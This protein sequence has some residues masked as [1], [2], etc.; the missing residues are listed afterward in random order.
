MQG[1]TNAAPRYTELHG[2]TFMEIRML[3][4]CITFVNHDLFEQLPRAAP[5]GAEEVSK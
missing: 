2:G 1:S 3:A 5:A 4:E